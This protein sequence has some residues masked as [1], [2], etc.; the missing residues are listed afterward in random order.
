VLIF[1]LQS[2]I[3]GQAMTEPKPPHIGHFLLPPQE[4][5]AT[6][7]NAERDRN[8]RSKG[9]IRPPLAFFTLPLPP[10]SEQRRR[11]RHSGQTRRRSAAPCCLRI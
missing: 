6:S 7:A 1:N 10:Q 5:Q 11:P 8:R 2:A 3:A 9:C 4:G